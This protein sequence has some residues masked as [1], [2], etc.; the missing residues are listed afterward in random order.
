MGR[1]YS[2]EVLI[3]MFA[4]Y[5][6]ESGGKD[7]GFT[8]VC[9]YTAT[10]AKWSAFEFDW[11]LFLATFRVPYLHMKEF[12]QSKKCYSTWRDNG[13]LRAQFLGMASEITGSHLQRA[14][15]G[16]VSHDGF[17]KA[18]LK[19]KLRERFNSPYALAGRTCVALANNRAKESKNGA[20]A[21]EYIFEDGCP[22]KEGLIKAVEA[23]PPFLPAPSFKPSRDGK[24]S[25]NWPEGR[26]GLVQLQA[27]DY[28][29]YETGKLLRDLYLI[30]SGEREVR[31]SLKAL[32]K[33]PVDRS[34]WGEV[35]LMQMCEGA[36]FARKD[37]GYRV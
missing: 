12:S 35:R 16:M 1:K 14:F 11:K 10:V 13:T 4:A 9:G 24:P 25:K 7:T 5:F 33:V 18:D 21:I 30:R 8:F 3:T 26:I 37:G 17:D 22:D 36:K 34:S 31:K 2:P 29:A 32:T 23:V 19:Y 20:L 28:L 15:I 27:A 6:D